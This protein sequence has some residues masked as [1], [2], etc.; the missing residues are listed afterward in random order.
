MSD[1]RQEESG[2][3]DRERSEAA[4]DSSDETNSEGNPCMLCMLT[5][6]RG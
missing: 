3:H 2:V 5:L 4:T 6:C 1:E